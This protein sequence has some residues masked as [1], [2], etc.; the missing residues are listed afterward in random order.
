MSV[1]PHELR[2]LQ[3]PFLVYTKTVAVAMVTVQNKTLPPRH[4]APEKVASINPQVRR[5]PS[6][7]EDLGV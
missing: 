6:K 7:L 1:D 5:P 4:L 2:T 3:F